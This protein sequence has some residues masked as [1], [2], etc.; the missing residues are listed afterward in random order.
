MEKGKNDIRSIENKEFC[1][2][3]SRIHT[4]IRNFDRNG[5]SRSIIHGERNR[6]DAGDARE[7]LIQARWDRAWYRLKL[8]SAGLGPGRIK[9]T[10]REND[11]SWA[12]VKLLRPRDLPV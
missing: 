12:G 8:R 3:C 11:F 1:W 9:K 4:K 10:P 2:T 7:I 6:M 5:W